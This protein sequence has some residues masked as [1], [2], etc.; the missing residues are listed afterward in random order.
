MDLSSWWIFLIDGLFS[1]SPDQH[2]R[3]GLL[4]PAQK[5]LGQA[6]MYSM[7][8]L[9][10]DRPD[11]VLEHLP[12]HVPVCFA[13]HPLQELRAAIGLEAKHIGTWAGRY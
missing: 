8:Q 10:K 6:G 1:G 5:L 9:S 7:V 12:A 3:H 4:V 13:S 11:A 2:G